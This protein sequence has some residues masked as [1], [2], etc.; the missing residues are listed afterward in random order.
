MSFD[1]FLNMIGSLLSLRVY[2]T[3]SFYV[4]K[5]GDIVKRILW[6][7]VLVFLLAGKMATDAL[8]SLGILSS[9]NDD[10]YA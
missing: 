9:Q 10:A 2:C 8:V 1:I 4:Q 3:P 6:G 7:F 5:G